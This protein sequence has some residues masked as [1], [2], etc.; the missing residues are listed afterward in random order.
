MTERVLS[1]RYVLEE[2]IGSGGMAEIWRA[3][4]RIHPMKNY[5]TQ[6]VGAMLN[7]KVDS[8]SFAD[9]LTNMVDDDEIARII[10]TS[11]RL[12]KTAARIT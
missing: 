7:L 8:G 6:A 4:A 10:C 2:R 11:R 1:G 12:S 5:L 3:A 9:G